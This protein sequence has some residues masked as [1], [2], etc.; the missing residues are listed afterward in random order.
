MSK[1][2]SF[3]ERVERLVEERTA[4]NADIREVLAEAKHSGID[5]KALREVIKLRKVE[6]EALTEFEMTVAAYREEIT[7]H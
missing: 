7:A 5:V 6:P 4:L 2:E 3:V 1:I